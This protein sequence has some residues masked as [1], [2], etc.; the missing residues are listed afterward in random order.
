[1]EILNIVNENDEVVG[2]DT[3]EN[4]HK[5]GLLHREINVFVLNKKKEIM[6]QKRTKDKDTYPGLLGSSVGGHL[7][8]GDNYEQAAIREFKEELGLNIKNGDLIFLKKIKGKRFDDVSNKINH[9]YKSIYFY[10]WD[11]K[12]KIVLDKNEVDGIV[13]YSSDE[14]KNLSNNEKKLFTP[15]LIEDEFMDI[16]EDIVKI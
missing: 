8:I 2:E 4:I 12:E 13:F 3:R 14:L 5:K 16:Y 11:E 6:F 10:R 9:Y 15:L 1:M 7:E